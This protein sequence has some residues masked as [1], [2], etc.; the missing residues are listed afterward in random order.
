M[1]GIK[2]K[3][4]KPMKYDIKPPTT[5]EEPQHTLFEARMQACIQEIYIERGRS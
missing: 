5:A 3:N 1:E 4:F 2:R